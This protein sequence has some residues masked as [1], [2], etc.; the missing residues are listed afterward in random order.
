MTDTVLYQARVHLERVQG[1]VRRARLPAETQPIWFGVHDELAA[2]YRVD[3]DE[4]EAHAAPLD[5]LVAAIGS[6]LLGVFGNALET[7]KIPAGEG[8]LTAEAVG[9]V[10]TEE[11][12]LVLKRVQVTYR[13]RLEADQR[14]TARRVHSFHARYCPLARTLE[15]SVEIT[16]TLKMEEE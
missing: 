10:V 3:P 6:S 12:I 14:A 16:T 2:Y 11:K 5:Y 13:L 4:E 8:R 1:H 7:R 15:E 9:D